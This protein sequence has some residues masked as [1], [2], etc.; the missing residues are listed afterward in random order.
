MPPGLAHPVA[1]LASRRVSPMPT[2][3]DSWVSREHGRLDVGGQPSRVVGGRA[4]ERL[5]PAPDLDGDG[6]RAQRG[7]H[8]GGGGV[9]RRLVGRQEHAVR[10]AAQRLGE[11]HAGVHAEGPGLVRRRG[12]HLPRPP[13]VAVAADDDG[14][15][16]ELGPP[17][18]LDG[19]QELVEIDVQHPAAALAVP[20]SAIATHDATS[21]ER[22]LAVWSGGA[23][24]RLCPRYGPR[25]DTATWPSGSGKGLQSPVHGFDSHRRLQ[26]LTG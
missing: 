4:D 26:P 23:A 10:A 22:Q 12:H 18:H 1:V 15:A 9:V 2:A 17:A 7:H 14:Q 8:L 5:V 19:R 20:S 3:H 13:R 25:P 21:A 16:G 11:R 6:E 24:S